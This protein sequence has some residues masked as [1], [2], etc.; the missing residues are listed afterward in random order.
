MSIAGRRQLPPKIY[1]G[2]NL[3]K[4]HDV[5]TRTTENSK[6]C[7]CLSVCLSVH[8]AHP[9][10]KQ[11]H[12]TLGQLFPWKRPSKFH[13]VHGELLYANYFPQYETEYNYDIK[14]IAQADNNMEIYSQTSELFSGYCAQ[15]GT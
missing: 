8:T 5:Q 9:Q 6:L 13:D 12:A 1:S 4:L 14:I 11:L 10:G 7:K 2:F 3:G 15:E